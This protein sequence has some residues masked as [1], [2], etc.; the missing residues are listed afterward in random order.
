MVRSEI[1]NR[2]RNSHPAWQSYGAQYQTRA[3]E[4]RAT[5][6]LLAQ[7]QQVVQ[8]E[9][10]TANEWLS[11]VNMRDLKSR[12]RISRLSAL[13]QCAEGHICSLV[14]EVICSRRHTNGGSR[15]AAIGCLAG[16]KD[17]GNV[18][19]ASLTVMEI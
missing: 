15:G 3:A 17:H 8:W 9:V 19:K 12:C 4:L 7:E 10:N 16:Q 5:N 2:L 13:E 6:S 14:K 18:T 11:R 1:V